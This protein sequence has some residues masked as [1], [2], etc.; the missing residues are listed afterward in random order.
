MSRSDDPMVRGTQATHRGRRPD[1][2]VTNSMSARPGPAPEQWHASEAYH[3]P[4]QQRGEP[5]QQDPRSGRPRQPEQQRPEYAPQFARYSGVTDQRRATS[6]PQQP[7]VPPPEPYAPPR[8]PQQAAHYAPD[9]GDGQYWARQGERYDG[10]GQTNA[11]PQHAYEEA[12]RA[13]HDAAHAPLTAEEYDERGG[14]HGDQHQPLRADHEPEGEEYEEEFE[15]EEPPRRRGLIY[16]AAFLSAI[17]IGAGAAVGYK[18]LFSDK[19]SLNAK[20]ISTISSPKTPTKGPAPETKT[21]VA[22]T[23]KE[24]VRPSDTMTT[25]PAPLVPTSTQPPPRVPGLIV[26]RP[27]APPVKDEPPVTTAETQPTQPATK[28]VKTVPF[29]RDGVPVVPPVEPPQQKPIDV[30]ATKTT[31]PPKNV[32][33][34]EQTPPVP[35][36]RLQA[37]PKST[38]PKTRVAVAPQPPPDTDA[39]APIVKK[40][41]PLPKAPAAPKQPANTTTTSTA[42]FVAVLS[43]QKSRGDA[44]RAFADL[45]QKYPAVLSDK[46]PEV[47]AADLDSGHWE[48][49]V[50]GPPASRESAK[51]VCEKLAAA[52]YKGCWVKPY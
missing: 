14:Y 40:R 36:A 21:K 49:L 32:E 52:G 38:P 11:V 4:A 2:H 30:L 18:L 15:D 13:P 34:A 46:Q 3:Y 24:A 23:K 19:G 22:D 29:T 50:V 5:S 9:Q 28:M 41:P 20:P 44:L 16:A 37:P 47:Q 45:Q 33:L 51:V 39:E 25:P 35:P 8:A 26:Q 27:P 12:Y 31:E 48:R 17:A 10:H 43:S 42:G 7:P 6:Y 1:Q